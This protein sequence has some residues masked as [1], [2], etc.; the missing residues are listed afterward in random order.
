[1]QGL[2]Y[3][4]QQQGCPGDVICER[5]GSAHASRNKLFQHL[6]E[7][8]SEVKPESAEPAPASRLVVAAREQGL[9]RVVIKPQGLPTMGGRDAS[10]LCAQTHPDL[11]ITEAVPL[12]GPKIVRAAPAHRLDSATGG[13]LVCSESDLSER[14]IKAS[15][16]NRLVHKRYRSLVVGHLEKDC[17]DICSPISGQEALTKYKVICRTPSNKYGGLTTVDLT[18]V[19][20]RRHQLRKHMASIGHPILGDKRYSHT[21]EQVLFLWAIHVDFPHPHN[22]VATIRATAAAAAAAAAAAETGNSAVLPIEL[23]RVVVDIPEPEIFEF[24]RAREQ[25]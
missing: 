3:A 5:C 17:G 7:C 15:F 25:A 8:G 20:G 23:E 24:M 1:M 6:R 9:Y 16:C 21:S 13:L 4:I 19:T 14:S 10:G 12:H 18:P 2:D 11:I 22:S